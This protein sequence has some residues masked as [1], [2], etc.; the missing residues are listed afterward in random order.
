VLAEYGRDGGFADQGVRN[1]TPHH[2]QHVRSL[3]FYEH[4]LP[5][6]VPVFLVQAAVFTEV[7][8]F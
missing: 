1:L 5:E 2:C 7:G 6:I 4:F 3:R 8:V